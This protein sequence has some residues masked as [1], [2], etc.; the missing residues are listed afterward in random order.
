MIAWKIP[1]AVRLE[2][3]MPHSCHHHDDDDDDDDDD[4]ADV[5]VFAAHSKDSA[6]RRRRTSRF[7]KNATQAA[8]LP[9]SPI[10]ATFASLSTSTA[11]PKTTST[12]HHH[13]SN[14]ANDE[15]RTR[16]DHS[17]APMA[18]RL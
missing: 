12:C 6:V 16:H 18:R 4:N 14:Q 5:T 3:V 2:F 11:E 1:N 15:A 17:R 8:A 10:D 9:Q 7:Q 13:E